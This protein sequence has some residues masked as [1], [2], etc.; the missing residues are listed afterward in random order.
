MWYYVSLTVVRVTVLSYEQCTKH[1]VTNVIY[2]YSNYMFRPPWPSSGSLEDYKNQ[3]YII[4]PLNGVYFGV[5]GAGKGNEISLCSTISNPRNY[6]YAVVRHTN[7]KI[8]L[9]SKNTVGNLLTHKTRNPDIYRQSGV[10]KL[11]CPDCGKAYV[12]HTGREFTAR[13]KE[14][15]TAYRTNNHNYSFAKHL[16]NTRYSFGPINEIM[17]VLHC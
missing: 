15:K 13:Y 14:H 11:T 12:G 1:N 17:S 2:V 3:L 16:S 8:A 9:H 4:G 7:L 5:R 6:I 10:Y